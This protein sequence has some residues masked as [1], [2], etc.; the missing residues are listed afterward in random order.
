MTVDL[1]LIA[2]REICNI[3]RQLSTSILSTHTRKNSDVNINIE[4]KYRN[5]RML[6]N[7]FLAGKVIGP[8]KSKWHI[9][10]I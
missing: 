6:H 2:A 7:F 3:F 8:Y 9:S 5:Q 10:K 4:I 1:N